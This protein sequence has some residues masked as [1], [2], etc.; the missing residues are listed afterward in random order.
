MRTSKVAQARASDCDRTYGTTALQALQ[1]KTPPVK[2]SAWSSKYGDGGARAVDGGR[3][4][5]AARRVGCRAGLFAGDRTR[6]GA[7]KVNG[8][9]HQVSTCVL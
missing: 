3:A 4:V 5:G 2:T 7:T 8:T 6:G 1:A 9:E